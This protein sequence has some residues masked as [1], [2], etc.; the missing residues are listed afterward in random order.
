MKRSIASLLLCAA[1]LFLTACATRWNKSVPVR[2]SRPTTIAL[3]ITVNGVLQPTPQQYAL[4]QAAAVREFGRL[5]YTL[6]TDLSLAERIVRIDFTPDPVSP[7][8]TGRATVLG[9]RTNPYYASASSSISSPYPTAFGY[10][11]SF[12][13]AN[14]YALN[15]FGYGYYGYSNSYYDGYSYSSPTLNPVQPTVMTPTRPTTPPFRHDSNH[16]PPDMHRVQPLQGT[17]AAE[18]APVTPANY[19]PSSSR[20]HGRWHGGDPGGSAATGASY[21]S[22]G[23]S[24]TGPTYAANSRGSSESRGS[25]RDRANSSDRGGSTSSSTERASRG[26]WWSA[27][28][29]RSDSAASYPSS[30]GYSSSSSS[31]SS[32]SSYSSSSSS[33]S[34]SS[35]SDSSSSSSSSSSSGSSSGGSFSGSSGTQ[36]STSSRNA[37]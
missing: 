12:S 34:Y 18:L 14:W 33:P 22:G 9:F 4:V 11:G 1:T 7:D 16:C 36:E 15:N 37:N 27:F 30:S 8:T 5:G 17:F 10:A 35:S 19:P 26:S 25:W 13:N 21:A 31:S 20:D 32:G 2:N 28:T 3:S 23:S 29:G 6:V 24:S